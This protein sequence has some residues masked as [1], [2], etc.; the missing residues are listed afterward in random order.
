[1]FGVDPRQKQTSIVLS[2]EQLVEWQHQSKLYRTALPVLENVSTFIESTRHLLTLSDHHGRIVY[3]AGEAPIR[4]R[5]EKMN[6][7]AGADWSE[8]SAG[9]NAIG[10][11]IEANQPIQIFSYEHYCEGCHNWVCSAAPIRDP[12]SGQLMGVVDF[13]GRRW[14]RTKNPACCNCF[15]K[16]EGIGRKWPGVVKWPVPLCTG[17]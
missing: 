3:L 8:A 17:S 9:T 10:T 1:M 13:S 4:R 11:C 6:F 16:R 2:D 14:N 12:F 15:T 7:V 5:A